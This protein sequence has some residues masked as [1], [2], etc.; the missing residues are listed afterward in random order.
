MND[1][2]PI[3]LKAA[4][5]R[6]GWSL[7]KL[8]Q[9]AACVSK[10]MLSKYEL[11]A[12]MPS[13]DVLVK[14]A[15]TLRVSTE[16]LLTN[17]ALDLR[18]VAF[19]K[20]QQLSATEGN[21][22]KAETE[23]RIRQRRELMRVVGESPQ[24]ATLPRYHA[25]AAADAEAH[26]A[27]LRASWNL[28]T[29]PLPNLTTLLEDKGFEIVVVEAERAF[30]GI[31]AWIGSAQP[32]VVVQDPKGDGARQRMN[33]THEL[34][35]IVGDPTEDAG[36]ED[37][38]GLFG[39]AFLFPRPAVQMEFTARRNRITLAELK[40]VKG[41][42]G[43]S[44]EAILRRLKSLGILSGEG[45]DWWYK[46]GGIK[47]KEKATPVPEERPMR[48]VR[49]ASKAICEGMV[50]LDT[51]RQNADFRPAELDDMADQHQPRRES[52]QQRYLKMSAEERQKVVDGEADR[53]AAHLARH[54]AAIIP[55]VFDEPD[56]D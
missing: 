10:A 19:R 5:L 8:S 28:G 55:D 12:S 42:Y 41:K 27:E 20:T 50:T 37:Y 23:W 35:H 54:P 38:A 39:A 47:A 24:V 29:G 1:L 43:I 51:L 15:A 11:G 4:R 18:F 45:C 7:D 22:I 46:V 34:G 2:F 14:L 33:L 25:T 17:P 53:V 21:R 49:L 52:L 32:V 16:A 31:S 6:L 26:A 13:R 3:H 56:D 48:P 9:E 30:S 36:A 44:F 40:S